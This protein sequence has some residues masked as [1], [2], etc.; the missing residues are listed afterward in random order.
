M[1][2]NFT[3][4][5]AFAE[6]VQDA[7]FTIRMCSLEEPKWSLQYAT[8]GSLRVQQGY[9]GGGSFTE[10]VTGSDGWTFFHQLPPFYANGKGATQDGVFAAPPGGEFCLACQPVHDWLTVFVP[11]SLL[12]PSPPE[13]EFAPPARPQL[14]KPPPH[15]TR[16]FTSL[17]RRFLSAA[18]HRPQ[19]LDSPVA[20][21]CFQNDLLAATKDLFTRWRDSYRRHFVR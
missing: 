13:L 11:T 20:L 19:L 9:E 6:A 21:D 15:V 16:R 5:E 18:E 8:V 10:G 7:S 2:L 1:S 3:E 4:F 12:F 14:L 17:V